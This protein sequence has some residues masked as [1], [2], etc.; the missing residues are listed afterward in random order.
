MTPGAGVQGLL[1]PPPLGGVFLLQG[2]GFD[3]PAELELLEKTF[4]VWARYGER[5][6]EVSLLAV[7]TLE[8]SSLRGGPVPIAAPLVLTAEPGFVKS[9]LILLPQALRCPGRHG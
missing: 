1:N 4:S 7:L 8:T 6:Q 2:S 3:G 9:L 5:S